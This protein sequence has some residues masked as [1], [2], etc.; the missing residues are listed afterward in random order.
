MRAAALQLYPPRCLPVPLF[1]SVDWFLDAPI[2]DYS[3]L[4]GTKY[5][6][7]GSA[8]VLGV[9]RARSAV[10]AGF[11]SDPGSTSVFIL[12]CAKGF[13]GDITII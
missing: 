11:Q 6:N 13:R 1:G 5:Y 7:T 3:D 8:C 4:N 2:S 9:P 10:W 12:S